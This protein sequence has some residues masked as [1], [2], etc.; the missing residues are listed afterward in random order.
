[1]GRESVKPLYITTSGHLDETKAN[2]ASMFGEHRIPF[3]LKRAD[4]LCREEAKGE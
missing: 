3:L 4:Q 2:V 1:M